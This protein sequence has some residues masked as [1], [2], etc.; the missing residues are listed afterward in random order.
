MIFGDTMVNYPNGKHAEIKKVVNYSRRGMSLEDDL[1]S[2][3]K[4]YLLIDKAAIY[5]KPTPITITKVDYKKRSSAKIT[6]AFFQIPSTTDY[7]GV[8]KGKYI[9]F[10]AK[11]THSKTSMPLQMIHAH[12]IEHM[13]RVIRYGGIAFLI[14]RFSEMN[15]TYFIKAQDLLA[16]IDESSKKSLP[17]SWFKEMGILIPY[18]Y[19]CKV[20]YLEIIDSILEDKDG[21]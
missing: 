17:Y 11:E 21:K 6:E 3:N 12:Q 2:T 5:K 16:Y 4:Y 1:N 20:D 10:E 14:A 7:N 8:Y 13:R 15:E 18:N 9:D 19:N